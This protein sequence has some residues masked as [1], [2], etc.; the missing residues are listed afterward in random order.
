MDKDDDDEPQSSVVST[1]FVK[2]SR[3]RGAGFRSKNSGLAAS[4][5]ASTTATAND[6]L[7]ATSSTAARQAS[8]SSR[9]RVGAVSLDD[10]DNRN[11]EGKDGASGG[12]P[13]TAAA[14]SATKSADDAEEEDPSASAV[15]FR[16]RHRGANR[17]GG[18]ATASTSASGSSK[19]AS[20]KT[21]ISFSAMDDGDEGEG[22]D[23][24]EAAFEIRR[25]KLASAGR[26]ERKERREKERQRLVAPNS[27]SLD[28]AS[29][30]DEGGSSGRP[31]ESSYSSAYIAELKAATPSLSR[32]P[33]GPTDGIIVDGSSAS[34]MQVDAM[35]SSGDEG[36]DLARLKFGAE[37]AHDAIP[38]ESV[39]RAAKEKRAKMRQMAAAGSGGGGEDFISLGTTRSSA[40]SLRGGGGG[41]QVR[42]SS[43]DYEG[44]HPESR[45]QR[46]ED[47]YGSGEEE[48][49]E[50]TGATERIPIGKKA[51]RQYRAQQRREMEEALLDGR[52]D[53]AAGASATLRDEDEEADEDEAEWERAQLRRTET[54]PGQA[55]DG[56]QR[57]RERYREKSPYR[58]ASIPL[59]APLPTVTSASARLSRKVGELEASIESHSAVVEDAER[60][61]ATLDEGER[62]NKAEVEEAEEKESWFR[63]LERFV[64]SLAGFMEAKVPKLDEVERDCVELFVERTRRVQRARAKRMEDEM[65][66]FW[67]V[68]DTSVL[69]PL[70]AAS[71]GAD[72]DAAAAETETE[73][74]QAEPSPLD[75]GDYNS[76]VR[77]ARRADTAHAEQVEREELAPADAAA[78]V[79]ARC[80]LETRLSAIFADVQAPEYLDAGARIAD[81]Q[82]RHP[83]SVVAR[84]TDWRRRYAI[85]YAQAW[86]GLALAS[87][88]EFYARWEMITFDALMA[89]RGE[90]GLERW[91]WHQELVGYAGA[92]GEE[93]A[94]GGDDEA[95]ATVVQN[96]VV[97]K[98][99]ALAE[100]GAYD[101]WSAMQTGNVVRLV[102]EVAYV[103]D[104]KAARFQTLL[105]TYLTQF[106]THAVHLCT[107]LSTSP[108]PPLSSSHS[109]K[110]TATLSFTRRIIAFLGNLVAWSRFVPA[111]AGAQRER[112]INLVDRVAAK[113]VWN[114]VATLQDKEGKAE[115]ARLALK[116]V[117]E[118][119]WVGDVRA[120]FEA[121]VRNAQ[122][123]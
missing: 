83:S 109:D 15:V 85:E 14:R 22:E 58:P 93:E 9:R 35:D 38:S 97:P 19:S 41:G 16:S 95:L 50:Y 24:Q 8:G 87:I 18:N 60:A 62:E 120:R 107:L 106:E 96:V 40:L 56:R 53:Y 27:L 119:L 113:V 101:P 5:A 67:G 78:L 25:S 71:R 92:H 37:L 20:R 99:L 13:T 10:D 39:V 80:E 33:T 57:E 63:E 3:P 94:G 117:P 82:Q 112:L 36:R 123:G 43:R 28:Q 42:A 61:L 45:L 104:T 73:K 11:G 103:V 47:E 55:R 32:R 21:A 114:T 2:R 29:I 31:A 52:N 105:T 110:T 12:R 121:I 76:A 79:V 89:Q 98:L 115:V 90:T 72:G 116:T 69:P 59:T 46:E 100:R 66:L 30:V 17:L 48:Y 81:T 34:A 68:A 118:A 75:D 26:E 84:F 88:W 108:Q 74:R 4:D 51:E 64:A 91:K 65:A 86:G 122:Q 111:S 49:A 54:V 102:D 6:D 7:P 44:P 1:S 23:R 77:Q 70:A